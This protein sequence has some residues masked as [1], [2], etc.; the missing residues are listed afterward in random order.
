M[1]NPTLTSLVRHDWQV[2]ASPQ[3]L[4]E[5]VAALPLTHWAVASSGTG[6][7]ELRNTSGIVGFRV[8]LA[9]AAAGRPDVAQL[10]SPTYYFDGTHG[11]GEL[12][13]GVAPDNQ[14]MAEAWD[15]ADPIYAGRWSGYWRASGSGFNRFRLIENEEQLLLVTNRTDDGSRWALFTGAVLKP[16]S[17]SASAETDG[18]L[19]GMMTTQ[20]L[21]LANG[22]LADNQAFPSSYRTE[23]AGRATNAQAGI[24]GTPDKTVWQRIW[25]FGTY[26]MDTTDAGLVDTAG[27]T[28]LLRLPFRTVGPPYYFVGYA[29]QLHAVLEALDNQTLRDGDGALKGYTLS[30]SSASVSDA[31]G[32]VTVA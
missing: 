27:D 18:R 17:D 19:K 32:L 26:H 3:A 21:A 6:W 4:L 31:V 22:M 29:R 14:T 11:Q 16:L 23:N 12:F 7:L 13:A 8:L 2:V 30:A 25:R 10:C 15:S 24:W 28:P 5:A 20:S 1:P 9:G